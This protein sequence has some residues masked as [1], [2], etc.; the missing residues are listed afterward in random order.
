MLESLEKEETQALI[1]R[2]G[3]RVTQA[4][5]KKTSYLIVGRDAGETKTNKV[6]F[7]TFSAYFKCQTLC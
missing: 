4:V 3:G 6:R 7:F 1:E 5:S 2:Y